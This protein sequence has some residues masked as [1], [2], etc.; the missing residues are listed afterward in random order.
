LQEDREVVLAAVTAVSPG[1]RA[2]TALGHASK[3]LRDDLEVVLAAVTCSG[4]A[5]EYASWRLRGNREVVLAAA[6]SKQPWP[7]M[8]KAASVA[9]RYDREI[10]LAATRRC[11]EAVAHSA[12]SKQA[13]EEIVAAAESKIA[14][15]G[16]EGAVLATVFLEPQGDE[17][18]KCIARIGLS[19]CH[20]EFYMDEVERT[21]LFLNCQTDGVPSH[22]ESI[23][24]TPLDWN[25]PLFH[26]MLLQQ[27]APSKTY[28]E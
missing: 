18:V 6:N 23:L 4:H 17:V 10:V 9:L 16:E 15:K 20:Q 5:L 8:L 12:L 25:L 19:G 24:M 13:R 11:P 26:F 3:L 7:E 27:D 22:D 21:F 14:Q 28:E 2:G 1:S